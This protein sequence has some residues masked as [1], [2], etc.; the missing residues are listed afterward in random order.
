MDLPVELDA[1]ESESRLVELDSA[2]AELIARVVRRHRSSMPSYLQSMQGE[3]EVVERI[4][5]K[6]G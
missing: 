2:E 5:K 1:G 3:V 4:L 6:V